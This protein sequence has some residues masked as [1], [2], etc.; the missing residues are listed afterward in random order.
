MIANPWATA[1]LRWAVLCPLTLLGCGDTPFCTTATYAAPNTGLT[2]WIGATGTVASGADLSELS[3]GHARICPSGETG[4]QLDLP[5]PSPGASA[6]PNAA[7]L[8]GRIAAAGYP[9]DAREVE[10]LSAV[11]AGVLSGPKG[12][13]TQ[14]QTSALRVID[15]APRYERCVLP[16]PPP[17]TPPRP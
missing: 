2:L 12:T 9:V 16:E 8:G 4:A 15:V 6:A 13:P 3:A 1:R 10:E 5:L 17:C 11:L 7:A 14:G